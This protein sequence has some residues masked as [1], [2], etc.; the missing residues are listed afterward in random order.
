MNGWCTIEVGAD[1]VASAFCW[2]CGERIDWAAWPAVTIRVPG[3][4]PLAFHP[5]CFE[6]YALGLR[7]VVE[8]GMDGERI[9]IH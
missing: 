6:R 1:P 2:V 5:V 3:H 4:E 9:R 7:Q 8:E